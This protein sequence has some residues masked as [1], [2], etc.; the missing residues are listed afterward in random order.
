MLATMS[1]A[2]CGLVGEHRHRPA[3]GVLAVPLHLVVHVPVRQVA[4][5][6]EIDTVQ[7]HPLPHPVGDDGDGSAHR[8]IIRQNG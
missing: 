7:A 1:L 3:E 2:V 8:A 5:P 4:V 6:A